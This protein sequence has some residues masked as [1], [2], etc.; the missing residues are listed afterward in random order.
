L[1]DREDVLLRKY[2]RAVQLAGKFKFACASTVLHPLREQTHY[3]LVYY[4]R[5]PK[6][7]DVFKRADKKAMEAMEKVRAEAQQE[8][9]VKGAGNLELFG[10]VEMKKTSGHYGF[11]RELHEPRER[12][13]QAEV[14]ERQA[15]GLRQG[16]GDRDAA[17]Y[18]LGK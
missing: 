5:S 7:V 10:A 18:G 3:H 6:G 16:M 13:R 14:A 8:A 17:A 9:R 4:T 12:L 15:L 1:Q 11:L 2:M